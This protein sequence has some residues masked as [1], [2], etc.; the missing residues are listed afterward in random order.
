[1][2]GKTDEC[3]DIYHGAEHISDCGKILF[4][5]SSSKDWFERMRRVLLSEGLVGLEC[6][7]KL[8]SGLK[9]DQQESL[10]S[11]LEYF[12]DNAGWLNYC[13]RLGL[14]RK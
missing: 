8:L 7:L 10:D 6:E 1:M 2:F 9:K 3:L 5:K 14:V 4:D 12:R 11:L 13:E